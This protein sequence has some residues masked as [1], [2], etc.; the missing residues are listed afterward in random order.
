M[1]GKDECPLFPDL[2]SAWNMPHTPPD[3]K[4]RGMK[5]SKSLPWQNSECGREEQDNG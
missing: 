2:L 1:E 5:T 4:G 3:A